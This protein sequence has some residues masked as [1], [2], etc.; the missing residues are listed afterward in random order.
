MEIE[1]FSFVDM[2]AVWHVVYMYTPEW[3]G[4]ENFGV[5][6]IR[7]KKHEMI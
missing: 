7:P 5:F 2:V 1:P 4:K 6:E 3:N